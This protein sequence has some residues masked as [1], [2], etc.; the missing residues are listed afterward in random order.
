MS[1]ALKSSIRQLREQIEKLS[2]PVAPELT[3]PLQWAERVAFK[4]DP[5][6]ADLLLKLTQD[7][8]PHKIALSCSRQVGKSTTSGLCAAARAIQGGAVFIVSPTLRQSQALLK[9]TRGF[10]E[11]TGVR[12]V[13][14]TAT[15]IEISGGGSVTAAPG[16][17]PAFIRGASLATPPMGA[18]SKPRKPSILIV[19]EA[20]FCKSELW[21]AV[22][23]MVAAAPD[24]S[25]VLI[26]T[27]CGLGSYFADVVHDDESGFEKIVI[28]A[29]QCP[30]ISAEY[31]AE[32]KRR[33]GDA[34]FS[35]EFEGKFVSTNGMTVFSA[36]AISAFF[37]EYAGDDEETI[38]RPETLD[39]PNDEP[40]PKIRM[41][42]F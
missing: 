19:D 3:D 12:V 17:M 42:S 39:Q 38:I 35:Q 33:L 4:P 26:S 28:T 36:E 23:P 40:T 7:N 16:N 6:Q 20:A 22:N 15:Y 1:S 8:D 21:G 14:E 18:G 10:V 29:E 27:P 32:Q 5:W 37:G 9:T 11:R 41:W 25:V 2:V 13:R 31:L 24:A 30:R 34:L